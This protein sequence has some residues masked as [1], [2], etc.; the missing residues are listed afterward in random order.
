VQLSLAVKQ[1]LAADYAQIKG[2][3]VLLDRILIRGLAQ[4]SGLSGIAPAPHQLIN[5]PTMTMK[6]GIARIDRELW[7]SGTSQ[8]Q[9]WEDWFTK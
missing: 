8:Q 3:R 9:I 6:I 1:G 4:R 5:R 7:I 2:D